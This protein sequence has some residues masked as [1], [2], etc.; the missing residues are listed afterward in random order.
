M[1]GVLAAD[2]SGIPVPPELRRRAVVSP[3]ARTEDLVS[4][5]LLSS[6][7]GRAGGDPIASILGDGSDGDRGQRAVD[8]VEAGTAGK[9]SLILTGDLIA[10]PRLAET[11]G[12]D[13]EED[14]DLDLDEVRPE[15]R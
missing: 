12:S 7:G 15:G 5:F 1:E 4:G 3:S 6:G 13:W 2:A 8:S 10:K 11:S 14:P 9:H